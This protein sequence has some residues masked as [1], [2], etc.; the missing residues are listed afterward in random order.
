MA[1]REVN[2]D[3]ATSYKISVGIDQVGGCCVGHCG[4]LY[5]LGGFDFK[6]YQSKKL[7]K[8]QNSFYAFIKFS[9]EDGEP[10]FERTEL[11]DSFYIGSTCVYAPEYDTAFVFGGCYSDFSDDNPLYFGNFVLRHQFGINQKSVVS[12][13]YPRTFIGPAGRVFHSAAWDAD[14][15][16][17]WVVAGGRYQTELFQ[18]VWGWSALTATWTLFSTENKLKPRWGHS[19][20]YHNGKIFVYGGYTSKE[21][22]SQRKL[23]YLKVGSKKL[24][25]W[26]SYNL[27]EAHPQYGTTM[28][29]IEVPGIGPR[30]IIAGGQTLHLNNE[31]INKK[32]FHLEMDADEFKDLLIT[33]VD[34]YSG[35]SAKIT[36]KDV[37]NV[38]YHSSFVMNEYLYLYGGFNQCRGG[39]SYGEQVIKIDIIKIVLSLFQTQITI[40][41]KQIH[42][43]GLPSELSA[44][45]DTSFP[46][47]KRKFKFF[48][49]NLKNTALINVF[50]RHQ[51]K[52]API[53]DFIAFSGNN[54]EKTAKILKVENVYMMKEVI[55]RRIG[56]F[57]DKLYELSFNH[58]YDFAFYSYTG[59]INP[60]KS[61][62][63]NFE[64]FKRFFELCL[65]FKY[66][67]LIWLEIG[68]H[69]SEMKPY[70]IISLCTVRD[71]NTNKPT[72]ENPQ[73]Q[74]LFYVFHETMRVNFAS[75][76]AEE[77]DT[78]EN[79]S[80]IAKYLVGF[81]GYNKTIQQIDFKFS[82]P[83]TNVL[84]DLSDIFP[85]TII[86]VNDNIAAYLGESVIFR[87]T[88]ISGFDP[89]VVESIIKCDM[90]MILDRSNDE[91]SINRIIDSFGLMNKM[92]EVN[93]SFI[94]SYYSPHIPFLRRFILENSKIHSAILKLIPSLVHEDL[95]AFLVILLGIGGEFEIITKDN[96]SII[97]KGSALGSLVA[98]NRFVVKAS[99]QMMYSILAISYM[100]ED[101]SV[102]KLPTFVSRNDLGKAVLSVAG[103]K[104]KII[105]P[106]ILEITRPIVL[107]YLEKAKE[108]INSTFIVRNF[109]G[110]VQIG[111]LKELILN[112]E[113]KDWIKL[114]EQEHRRDMDEKELRELFIY[115]FA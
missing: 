39:I 94:S 90:R 7:A 62:Y 91:D 79:L 42:E 32:D 67:R 51:E 76:K 95:F 80:S 84:R 9:V 22:K 21:Q 55:T 19:M 85:D 104:P 82:I 83:A 20:A 36:V 3:C 17:M 33:I 111:V 71:P 109:C 50:L 23:Y 107:E 61:V 88:E 40:L 101:A 106:R 69:I 37:K 10:K 54:N 35:L 5:A 38:A 47:I 34:P 64:D 41:P 68:C 8:E 53:S 30:I 114:L 113:S 92:R 78:I 81:I 100:G 96:V 6:E 46:Q 97:C 103:Q 18:D 26:E 14:R 93:V 65:H 98:G 58:I 60:E 11:E 29:V 52:P 89:A 4:N 31:L 99:A 56:K 27:P 108:K 15:S 70:E 49:S 112:Q 77:L 59:L 115:K 102:D 45:P 75:I 2:S 73:L 28:N 25:K 24:P 57:T 1:T 87:D 48:W 110:A 12:T 74:I 63:S 72:M 105:L 16:I 43:F 44:V 86:H 66:Y 13:A